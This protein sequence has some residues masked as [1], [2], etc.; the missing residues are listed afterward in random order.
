M[1]KCSTITYCVFFGENIIYWKSMKQNVVAQSTVE[2]QR[3][4]S[5]VSLYR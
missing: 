2:R 3:Q 5:L 4:L 1:G